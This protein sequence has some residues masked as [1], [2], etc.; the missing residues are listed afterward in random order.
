M[1][2]QEIIDQLARRWCTSV[3]GGCAG[4]LSIEPLTPSCELVRKQEDEEGRLDLLSGEWPDYPR[5]LPDQAWRATVREPDTGTET[6]IEFV[7]FGNL[8][9]SASSNSLQYMTPLV[10]EW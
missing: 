1:T 2:D 9:Y 8:I 4:V 7:R 3:W 6:W 5:G 10:W